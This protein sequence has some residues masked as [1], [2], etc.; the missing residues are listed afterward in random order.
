M[1]IIQSYQIVDVAIDLTKF[2][3]KN[4]VG[5]FD[6]IQPAGLIVKEEKISKGRSRITTHGNTNILLIK[7]I[8]QRTD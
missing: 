6:G 7:L 5:L 8:I 1:V 3:C 2:A 4:A